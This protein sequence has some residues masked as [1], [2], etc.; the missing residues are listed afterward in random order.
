MLSD[1]IKQS[2][3][4]KIV[5]YHIDLLLSEMQAILAKLSRE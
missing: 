5:L 3:K 2:K 1:E 4:D